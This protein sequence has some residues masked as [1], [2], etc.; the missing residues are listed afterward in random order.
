MKQG[1]N[2]QALIN[3]GIVLLPIVVM[4]V[5]MIIKGEW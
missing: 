3:L 5:A 2:M 1:T 4:G